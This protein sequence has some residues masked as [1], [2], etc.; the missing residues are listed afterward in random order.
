MA[1]TL[2]PENAM[3]DVPTLLD[4]HVVL[5]HECLDRLV[6]RSLRC[7]HRRLSASAF[8]AE[9]LRASHLAR[10]HLTRLAAGQ[11]LRILVRRMGSALLSHLSLRVPSDHP[12]GDDRLDDRIR[13]CVEASALASHMLSDSSP[14]PDRLTLR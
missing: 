7:A 8:T 4:E 10:I 14:L 3:P 5:E 13:Y 11:S 6:G 9:I 1:S 12:H 2:E